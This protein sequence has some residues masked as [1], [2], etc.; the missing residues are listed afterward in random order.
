MKLEIVTLNK[1][2]EKELNKIDG[3][4]ASNTEDGVEIVIKKNKQKAVSLLLKNGF[5]KVDIKDSYPSLL[6]SLSFKEFIES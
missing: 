2:L 6:E 4:T 3:V 1:E 5:D